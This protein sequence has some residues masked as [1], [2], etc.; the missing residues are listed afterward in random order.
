[1]VRKVFMCQVAIDIP[2]AVIYDTR[3]TPEEVG[4]F[5]RRAVALGYYSQGGVSIGYCA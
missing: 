2:D 1:M 3:M 4:R 5:A